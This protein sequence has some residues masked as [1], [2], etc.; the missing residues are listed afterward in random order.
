MGNKNPSFHFG[1]L[2]PDERKKASSKGQKK[3]VESRKRNTEQKK[4][5]AKMRE[6][7]QT[8]LDCKCK[9]EMEKA[10]K[11]RGIED[12]ENKTVMTNRI[13]IA[14]R[15]LSMFMDKENPQQSLAAL[16]MLLD[17]AGESAEQVDRKEIAEVTKNTPEDDPFSK[18]IKELFGGKK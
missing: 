13:V 11:E 4:E 15:L 8:L 7:V 6:V 14:T 16:K 10:M 17:L 18:S 12:L 3:S 1:D 9:P 5:T 2:P